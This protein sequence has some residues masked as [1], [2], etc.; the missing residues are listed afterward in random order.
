MPACRCLLP[1]SEKLMLP[2]IC[3]KRT[4]LALWRLRADEGLQRDV[5]KGRLTGLPACWPQAG[6]SPA[7]KG[8]LLSVL[9]RC[10]APH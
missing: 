4:S 6:G 5:L 2:A 7:L 10:H 3:A 8:A 1:G 9:L